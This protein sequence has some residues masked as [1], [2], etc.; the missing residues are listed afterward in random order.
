MLNNL[1]LLM[2]SWSRHPYSCQIQC[3]F[4]W[5]LFN[6]HLNRN[7]AFAH[8]F[9]LIYNFNRPIWWDNV[10]PLF[11]L[12][13]LSIIL[14]QFLLLFLEPFWI[15]LMI[16]EDL[17][18][19]F[20]VN[21]DYLFPIKFLRSIYDNSAVLALVNLTV[22]R[23]VHVP[24]IVHL[25]A[26]NHV[27]LIW[28][29]T[30]LGC[31]CHILIHLRSLIWWAVFIFGSTL[32]R[33]IT[34]FRGLKVLVDAV[35]LVGSVALRAAS[36]FNYYYAYSWKIAGGNRGLFFFLVFVRQFALDLDGNV[37]DNDF[38]LLD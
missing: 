30:F 31:T 13:V 18:R 19:L 35:Q 23:N 12:S 29:G 37:L 20:I 2:K 8:Q 1:L 16:N 11:I 21:L 34:T 7:E 24:Q 15:R 25:R 22:P 3:I 6:L 17:R 5:K 36:I 26:G 14:D 32:W 28:I 33:L 10:G 4:L 27:R 38:H 9:I